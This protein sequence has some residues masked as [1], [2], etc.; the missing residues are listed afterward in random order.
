VGQT[1]IVLIV[2]NCRYTFSKGQIFKD[3]PIS[4]EGPI[5][6]L[7]ARQ[8]SQDIDITKNGLYRL[9]FSVP[10]NL[11]VKIDNKSFMVENEGG[12]VS[13]PSFLLKEGKHHLQIDI[14][15]KEKIRTTTWPLKITVPLKNGDL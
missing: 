11:T 2:T 10:G 14:L 3:L 5:F 15:G 1:H 7:A 13:T 8:L 4:D 6:S 9:T 12:M